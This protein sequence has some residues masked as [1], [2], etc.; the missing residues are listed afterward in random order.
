MSGKYTSKFPVPTRQ[1][2]ANFPVRFSESILKFQDRFRKAYS[3]EKW[4]VVI[5]TR[6]GNRET[7]G[8]E[9]TWKWRNEILAFPAKN[10]A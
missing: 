10:L 9:E 3:L 2:R 4:W 6:T 5:N 8:N 1:E 7:A